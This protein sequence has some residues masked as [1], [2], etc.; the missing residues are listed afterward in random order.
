VIYYSQ[1]WHREKAWHR[2]GTEKKLGNI[3]KRIVCSQRKSL[4][5]NAECMWK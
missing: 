3:A 2:D 4:A 1:R 5:P